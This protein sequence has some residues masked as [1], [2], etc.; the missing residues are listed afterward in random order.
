[1]TGRLARGVW[2]I[3][4]AAL[5][6]L[7]ALP[8]P[9][10]SGA[11][12]RG[13][14]W[15]PYAAS[16]GIGLVVVLVSGIL[17]GRLATR[18]APARIP[19]PQ[20]RPFPA[21]AA[22]S[23][24]LMLL[25][26]WVMQWVFASNPQL[27]D[28]MAQLFHA[29]AFAG[30]RLAAPAPQPPEAFLV[31]HTWITPAGWVSLYPPGQTALLA[32]GLLARAEWLVNPLL[33]GL[34]VGL[35]YYTALGLYGRRTALA[36]AFLWATSAWVMFMSGTYMNHVGAV[37]FSLLAWTMVFGS[38]RPT[39]LRHAVAG[40]GLA[41]VAATRP[42]DA[43]GAAL[44]VLIWMAARRQ[45]RALPWMMLGG[46]PVILVWG[47]VNWR[48]FGSPLAI[49]YTAVYGEQ[50]GLGFGADPWG[51]PYTPFIALSNMA[52]AVRRLHIYLYEWPIPALLPLGIWA[53]AAGPR[54]WRDLVVGVGAAAIPALYFFYWHSGFYTGPRFYYGAV[55]FLV[56]GTARA[57]R[58]AWALARRSRVRQVRSD[59]ALAAVAA[60]VMLWGWIA[61][62]PRRADVHRRSLATLK[63]HPEREL[64][65]RGVRRALVLVPES[66]GSRIIVR[67]WGLGVEPGLVERAH[68]RLDTCDLHRFAVTAETGS[69]APADV[70]ARLHAMMDTVRTPPLLTDWPD[71]SVRLR[72]GYSPPESCQVELRRDLAGFTLYGHLAWRNPL[73]LDSGVVFARDLFEHNDRVLAR[74]PG[75]DVW[76]Y[77]PPADAPRALPVLSRLPPAPRLPAP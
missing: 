67:L 27:I 71:P 38:R 47:Y 32:L 12:D 43:V 13:P 48:T 64:A 11:P 63:L 37:T 36:A 51:Q 42:L 3:I 14:L 76:R 10:W 6:V 69:W 1:M 53:I 68:R 52:V 57:W 72:P 65:A 16:W 50:F 59:V 4:G 35:V 41:A 46:V 49:G 26:V 23:I 7:P 24:G 17:A 20:L 40:L 45:W 77:A 75:W 19:W 22:L 54:A 39:R 31:T 55:P 2:L 25:A 34:S 8:V 30:G 29:R 66:W 61:I 15:P 9:A 70:A 60:F 18:L 62:L 73:G 33:G 21:V 28:E 44:P 56:I 74:Y 5:L 58:W